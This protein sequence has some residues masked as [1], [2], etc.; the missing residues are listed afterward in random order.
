M[1][2]LQSVKRFCEKVASLVWHIFVGVALLA[3]L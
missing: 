1:T 2:A 3:A